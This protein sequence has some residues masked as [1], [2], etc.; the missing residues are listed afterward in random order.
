MREGGKQ[1]IKKKTNIEPISGKVNEGDQKQ[2]WTNFWKKV[3][4]GSLIK[5]MFKLLRKLMKKLADKCLFHLPKRT[6]FGSRQQSSVR[7]GQKKTYA[8]P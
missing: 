1:T 5:K 7:A 3:N 4:E 6:F 2:H 8:Q